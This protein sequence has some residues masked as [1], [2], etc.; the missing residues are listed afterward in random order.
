M[1]KLKI[2]AF[3]SGLLFL[4][5]GFLLSTS[6]AKAIDATSAGLVV[7]PPLTEKTVSSS[8]VLPGI[9]KISN[10]NSESDLSVA[11]T[12]E[13]FSANG[14][15][16]QQVFTD[17]GTMGDWITIEKSF[18]LKA[19][20]TKEIKYSINTPENAEP[21]GHYGVIFFSPTIVSSSS[22]STGSS[23][24]AIPK[25]GALLLLTV[26]GNI[27]YDARIAEFKNDK[28]LY[29]DINNTVNILTR[30]QNLGAN[31][32]KP[33]GN[34]VIKNMFGQTVASLTVNEKFGNVLPDSIR[35]FENEWNKK[36]GFGLY[37]AEVNLVY[38][39]NKTATGTLSFWILPWILI[40]SG[41]VFIILLILIIRNLHWG[42][43]SKPVQNNASSNQNITAS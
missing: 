32:V 10:S 37:K 27:T 15:E 26:P 35:R 16:G 42:S 22:D 8:S 14:E 4:M 9:I 20:E 24:V 7:S 21:G 19:S 38:S 30:F 40:A 18:T 25:I 17:S 2:L 23:V 3:A 5:I 13:N 12:V 43:G 34:I 39:D 31:H 11:V 28:K 36:Y 1:K 6:P 41:I 29:I 33:T